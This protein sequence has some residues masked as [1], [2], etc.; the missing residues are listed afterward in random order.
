MKFL[1]TLMDLESIM[2]NGQSERERD[3]E[4]SLICEIQR[5]FVEK[6]QRPK[7]KRNKELF[8]KT[9]LFLRSLQLEWECGV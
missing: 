7:H 2:L 6:K 5:K 1:V 9:E 8:L 3:T 4:S